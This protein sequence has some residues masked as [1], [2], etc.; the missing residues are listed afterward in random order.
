[1]LQSRRASGAADR[2]R[3]RG[4]GGRAEEGA[5]QGG[6][7]PYLSGP[8][9]PPLT[10]ALPPGPCG[11]ERDRT[12]M[13]EK[14]KRG[15]GGRWEQ[16]RRLSQALGLGWGLRLGESALALPRGPEGSPLQRGAGPG[17]H[18]PGPPSRLG[19]SQRR[20]P[21][22][23]TLL[24]VYW[25]SPLFISFCCNLGVKEADWGHLGEPPPR[26]IW[27]GPVCAAMVLCTAVPSGGTQ[28]LVPSLWAQPC[29]DSLHH[30]HH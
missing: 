8:R 18:T 14:K 23:Q 25:I 19:R 20:S 6:R 7:G 30:H 5:A 21:S 1:M 2:G 10:S 28:P 15:G 24:C 26:L 3:E 22:L 11:S 27:S 12:A 13:N 29:S 9:V 16:N 17:R 4:P